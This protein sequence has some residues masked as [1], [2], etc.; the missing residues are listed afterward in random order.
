[1]NGD[2]LQ[3][4]TIECGIVVKSLAYIACHCYEYCNLYAIYQKV[5]NK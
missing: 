3:S 4:K 1:M 2:E 5:N